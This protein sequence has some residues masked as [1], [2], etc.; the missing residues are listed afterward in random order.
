MKKNRIITQIRLL[1]MILNSS[2]K[3][4]LIGRKRSEITQTL[5]RFI[6]DLT[7]QLLLILLTKSYLILRPSLNASPTLPPTL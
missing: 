1:K 3:G 7:L 2:E 5:D 6:R 4:L